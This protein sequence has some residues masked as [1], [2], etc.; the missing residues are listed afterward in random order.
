MAYSPLGFAFWIASSG[1]YET[2]SLK[3]YL[4]KY[5]NYKNT[6]FIVEYPVLE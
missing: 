2:L 5:E 3:N 4:E 6:N 1:G